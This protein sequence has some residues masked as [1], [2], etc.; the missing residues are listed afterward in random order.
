MDAIEVQRQEN[1]KR[2]QEH[3]RELGIFR[4]QETV[5]VKPK[6]PAAK[7]RKIVASQ[8]SR[9]SARI[10]SNASAPV[11]KDDAED[12]D[13][14]RPTKV[15]R[16]K[17]VKETPK[18]TDDKTGVGSRISGEE[19]ESLR[20]GWAT[21]TPTADLP[22]RD[23][24]STFHFSSHPDFTPNKS[25]EE[26]LR[27][28]CFGGS[29]YRPLYSKRLGITIADDYKELP[30]SWL[31]GLPIDTFVASPQY[32]PDVNKFKVS[33][34]QS[35]EE[36]EAA[37][38]INHEYDVRGWFQWCVHILHSVLLFPERSNIRCYRPGTAASSWA[39]AATTT[40]VKLVGGSGV[41]VKL[42]DGEGCSSRNTLPWESRKC[43]TTARMRAIK[44][45]ARSCIKPAFTGLWKFG[46]TS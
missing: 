45:S 44:A 18:N 5:R 21:W 3:L 30:S 2:N 26:M 20:T 24:D 35:I 32:D 12:E 14:S 27:E 7:R 6:Q 31:A 17:G 4:T 1:I 16:L 22:V 13:V 11:Y 41:W 25:P 29:Y 23:E 15:P 8:P 42:A 19:L 38:W 10:A 9:V 39:G 37:G 34:G 40:S 46:R 28:G 36:W 43:L 33:C